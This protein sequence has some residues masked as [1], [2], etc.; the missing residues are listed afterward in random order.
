MRN[1]YE[2]LG[3]NDNA[4]IEEV[5]AAYKSLA[6]KYQSEDYSNGP[7]SEN[8]QKKMDEINEAYDTIISSSGSSA[9][10]QQSY[11][12]DTS[13]SSYPDV[14]SLINRNKLEE[15]ETILDGIYVTQRDAEWYYLKGQIHHRRGWFD[16]ARKAYSKACELDPSNQE[17]SAALNSLNNAATGGY[18][19]SRG[20]SSSGCCSCD[21][22]DICSSLLCADCC[23]ECMG[24][25]LIKCC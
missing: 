13:H 11:Y 14:R 24:G 9:K 19:T 18:R 20:N 21:A 8:A 15:A 12:S 3:L 5:K 4:S 10:N 25:D 1:P 7:L 22:C 17:Y 23:C 6:R 16:E 2:V